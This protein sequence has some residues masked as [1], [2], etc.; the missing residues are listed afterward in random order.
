MVRAFAAVQPLKNLTV[1][2]FHHGGP[3]KF[4]QEAL[5]FSK[6]QA[7]D[8]QIS[9]QSKIHVG[10]SLK[11]EDDFRRE[12]RKFLL[13]TLR[14]NKIDLIVTA[15][16]ADD[17]LETRLLRLIRG[18]GPQGLP[19]I[20]VLKDP[21]FRP[22]LNSP[23]EDLRN[24]LAELGQS[25]WNDPTNLDSK[26]LRNWVRN[27]WLP[28][29]EARQEGA[30][31]S[32]ARSIENCAGLVPRPLKFDFKRGLSRSLWEKEG[33]STQ[34]SLLAAYLTHLGV[35][36]FTRGQLEEVRKRLDSSR[37]EHTF[38]VAGCLWKINAQQIFAEPSESL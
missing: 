9:F 35:A 34:R 28:Q 22:F 23:R 7:E 25:W 14:N 26:F 3:S 12:R 5:E 16:H 2:H 29:L 19:A 10:V 1:V 18:T 32:L 17:L 13:Q 20:Q 4:R 38:V 21:W 6:K 33:P 36:D 37:K 24:Y 15:H 30:V 11:S 31:K 27:E 8:L